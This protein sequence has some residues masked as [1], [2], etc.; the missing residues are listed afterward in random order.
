ML[1][2]EIFT[3]YVDCC[4]H[5][6]RI[7]S[8]VYNQ[9]Q[10]DVQT[11]ARGAQQSC[12]ESFVTCN[13]ESTYGSSNPQQKL[14]T[15]SLVMDL[16]VNCGLPTWIV[17]QPNFRLFLNKMDPKFTPPCR[18]TVTYSILPRLKLATQSKLQELLDNS[19]DISLTA[20]IWTDRRM[21]SFLGVTVH[22][23]NNGQP[24]SCLLS[25]QSFKG[26]HTG[27]KIADALDGVV[28]D[29]GLQGRVRVRGIVTD[30]ASNM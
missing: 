17:D 11:P 30:N 14:L 22:T 3:Y 26:S 21:H 19:C 28:T 8:E 6:K 23:F 29:N 2:A 13:R 9:Y 27:Q 12:M 20:D 4:R 24:L 10:L 18:Q 7:H 16:I 5:L 15:S 1:T 25:I